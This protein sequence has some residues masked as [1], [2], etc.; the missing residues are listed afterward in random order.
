[1]QEEHADQ[2]IRAPHVDGANEPAEVDLRHDRANTLERLVGRGLVIQRQQNPGGH[3]DCKQKQGHP[4]QKVEERDP[5]DG[6][7]LLGRQRLGGFESQT[8]NE[9]CQ[10]APPSRHPWRQRNHHALRET[11]ISSC[12]GFPL[13]VTL[14]ASKGRGGG[15]ET[16]C[17]LKS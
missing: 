1:M 15:P 10:Q 5:V 13:K 12:P 11:M 4:S 3:L 7:A 16:L 8:V 9:E 14:Y 17:P 2:Q 6:D